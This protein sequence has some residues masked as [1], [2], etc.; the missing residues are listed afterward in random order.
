MLL[1][2]ILILVKHINILKIAVNGYEPTILK[3]I[4][5]FHDTLVKNGNMEPTQ[6]RAYSG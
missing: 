6:H 5:S 1:E 3:V 2:L 4:F